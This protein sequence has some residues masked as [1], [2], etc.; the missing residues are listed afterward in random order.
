MRSLFVLLT[1]LFLKG[2]VFKKVLIFVPFLAAEISHAQFPVQTTQTSCNCW[3]V[4][5]FITNRPALSSPRIMQIIDSTTMRIGMSKIY[6]D[7]LAI[8]DSVPL[9][10][11]QATSTGRL[12][13][14]NVNVLPV[15][16]GQITDGLGFTPYNATNPSGYISSVPAQS[17]ASLTG[18]PTTL[19]GYGIT[20]AYPLLGNP[21]SFLVSITSGNVTT[22]L[23]YTPMNPS[24]TT[25]QYFRGDGSLSTSLTNLSSFTNGPGYITG[26]ISS[27]VT[28]AL[29]FT[30]YNST[31]PSVFITASSSSALTNKTGNI[32]Q[33][34]NNSAYLTGNQTVTLSGDV[35]GSGGTSITTTLANSG[36]SAGTYKSLTVNAKGLATAGSGFSF[37]NG[38]SHSIVTVA[39]AGNGFQ[40][41]ATKD[42][43]VSY[44][45]KIATAVQIGVVTNVEG[46]VSLEIAATNSSTAGDWTEI[47]RTSSGTNIGL[48]LALSSTQ[49][50]TNTV[51]G[52]VPAGYYARIRSTNVSGTPVYTYITGQEASF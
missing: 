16:S 24:G 45:V 4:Y 46:Y 40:I 21:S 10:I 29:G 3:F 5:P 15:S 26:I 13:R 1:L 49:T 52:T 22:A 25:G 27:D 47:A 35:T 43:L 30:P 28:T 38:V 8:Y 39:A 44:S 37:N 33:W 48:A 31:N 42:A 50:L 32:S 7:S 18:K 23:G 11:L 9:T 20:D 2:I 14:T 19:S 34:T 36:V 51:N 12:L 17:F 41:S 6:F